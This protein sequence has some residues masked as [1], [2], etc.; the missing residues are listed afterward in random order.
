VKKLL[1]LI[2]LPIFAITPGHLRWA[3]KTASD[4]GAMRIAP[5]V[6]ATTVA[7]MISW[8]A[9]AAP[10]ERLAPHET[11]IYQVTATVIG[12]KIE[13]DGDIHVVLYDAGKMMVAEIPDVHLIRKSRFRD[14]IVGAR[15]AFEATLPAPT[16]RLRKVSA[17]VRVTGVGFFDKIHGQTGAAPNGIELHPVLG[18][19]FLPN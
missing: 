5:A 6:V 4:Q 16:A 8:P 17:K 9:P 1:F 19:E 7:E 11:T 2:A 15:A 13:D 3:V 12:Y 18:I 10:T 14:P